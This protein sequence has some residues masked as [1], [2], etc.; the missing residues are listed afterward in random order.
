[1]T[2]GDDGTCESWLIAARLAF[3]LL[4]PLVVVAAWL[5][6]SATRPSTGDAGGHTVRSL[7]S[8]R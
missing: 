8:W 5:V 6:A 4:E 2:V 7:Q 3:G 1:M